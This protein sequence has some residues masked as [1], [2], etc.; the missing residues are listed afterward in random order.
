MYSKYANI[1]RALKTKTY[2]T[3]DKFRKFF[4]FFSMNYKTFFKSREIE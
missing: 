2:K 4:S 3:I 1:K